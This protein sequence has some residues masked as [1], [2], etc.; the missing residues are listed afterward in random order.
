MESSSSDRRSFI[1]KTASA[2]AGLVG[3]AA[4]AGSGR[5]DLHAAT[6]LQTTPEQR[7][8]ELGITLPSP[9]QP[10]ATLVPVVRTGNLLFTSGHGVPRGSDVR[11]SGKVGADMTPEEGQAAARAVGLNILATVRNELGTLDDV[12]RLVKTLGM[13][14]SAPDFTGQSGV[15]N[16]FSQLMIDVFGETAGKGARSAVGMASLP[17]GWAVEIEAIF[18]VRGCGLRRGG[19]VNVEQ[20]V[21]GT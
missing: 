18:E 15:V 6:V 1:R 13:V 8:R 14:N 20:N 9:Q 16:G 3:G 21:M 19:L 11:G 2:G 10:F 5:P 17:G 12:V 7:L 4:L